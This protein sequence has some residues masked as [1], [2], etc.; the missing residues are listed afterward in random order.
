MPEQALY[1]ASPGWIAAALAALHRDG[2]EVVAP[3]RAN[4]VAADLAR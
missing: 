3:V 4:G 1:Q 2:V